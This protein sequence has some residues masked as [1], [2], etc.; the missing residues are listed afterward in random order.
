MVVKGRGGHGS[1]GQGR[2][3]MH[4][5]ITTCTEFVTIPHFFLA[6]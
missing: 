3:D 1:E 5:R 4:A 2:S 6:V